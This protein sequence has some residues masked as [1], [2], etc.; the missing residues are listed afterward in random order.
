MTFSTRVPAY[1][2]LITTV[3]E[4]T[5]SDAKVLQKN[6]YV[7]ILP[8]ASSLRRFVANRICL[9]IPRMVTNCDVFSH[10]F[11]LIQHALS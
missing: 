6:R 1:A 8:S 3:D 2:A 11:Q 10:A 7:D 4:V 5:G 9:C